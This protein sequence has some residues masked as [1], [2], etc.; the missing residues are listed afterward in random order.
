[1]RIHILFAIILMSAV[2]LLEK[3]SPLWLLGGRRMHP[4]A[5]RWLRFVPTAILAALLFPEILFHKTPGAEPALFLSRDNLFLIASIPPFIV[6][7]WKKSFFGA[8]IAGIA[9]IA[10]LRMFA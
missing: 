9:T 3:A 7:Y 8:I 6:A 5:E 1:M 4:V 2:T 10:I